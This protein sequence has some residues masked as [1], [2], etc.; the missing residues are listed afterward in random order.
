ML[1]GCALHLYARLLFELRTG[2][3]VASSSG[4]DLEPF[5]ARAAER[6]SS[7]RSVQLGWGA[8]A[9]MSLW[10][11]NVLEHRGLAARVHMSAE[12]VTADV[13]ASQLCPTS[14][15]ASEA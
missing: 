4:H 9:I 12:S 11:S 7:V 3:D 1:L 10:T 13:D 2:V 8:M 14:G 6:P 5:R 15:L